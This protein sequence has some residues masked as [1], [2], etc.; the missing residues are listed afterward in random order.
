VLT[1]SAL[2]P[3]D[4]GNGTAIG[5]TIQVRLMPV[6]DDQYPEDRKSDSFAE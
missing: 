6:H 3:P 2:I 4:R 5:K 1:K